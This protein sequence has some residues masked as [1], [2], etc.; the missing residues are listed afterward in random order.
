MT[1]STQ[2]ALKSWPRALIR[3]STSEKNPTATNQ[4]ANPTM[5]QRFIRVWPRNSLTTVI[6]RWTGSSV[7]VPAGTF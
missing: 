3:V 4:C 2:S 1:G 6:V 5:P 7:R